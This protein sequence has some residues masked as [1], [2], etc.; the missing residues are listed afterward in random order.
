[1]SAPD[2]ARAS[3]G[4]APRTTRRRVLSVLGT[5]V[6]VT[7][8][9]IFTVT[10]VAFAATGYGDTGADIAWFMVWLLVGAMSAA[11]LV[12]RR[13]HPVVVCLATAAASVL[14]PVGWF[15]PLLAL[16]WVVAS[17]SWRWSVGCAV[18]TA[19]AVGAGHR[20]DL[21]RAD[22]GVIFG[23]ADTTSGEMVLIHP[24]GAVAIGAGMLGVAVAVGL[25][26]RYRRSERLAREAE[27]EHL[28]TAASLRGQLSRQDERE[29]IA[30]EKHDTVAH[31]LSLVS[32]Q[33]SALEVTAADPSIDVGE[34]ARSMRSAAQRALLEM[35][36]LI[37]T[38]RDSQAMLT[39]AGYTGL[40]PT[41]ANLPA[42]ID[43]AR[44][45]GANVTAT[46]YVTEPESAPPML[47]RAVYR[48][49]QE[50]LTNALKHAPGAGVAVDVR[51]APRQG[52]QVTVRNAI[53][54]QPADDAGGAGLLGMRER[55]ESLGGTLNAGHDGGWFVVQ[56]TLP[57][58]VTPAD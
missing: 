46:V 57:W 27:W 22:D 4:T 49:V 37:T 7:V 6:A 12:W 41:L 52:V 2:A 18:A 51:A 23:M 45:A 50:S 19:L 16:V 3:A 28:R 24:A 38:L 39:D 48:I 26:R 42:L 13:T 53:L 14:L 10:E 32:L 5:T 34:S 8:S 33:A 40:T 43:E 44:A 15:P 35:R 58:A 29:V 54:S 36:T 56:A 1:M 21:R 55:A 9:I 11:A 47:T 31:Q 20:R 17:R 25:V 30:R